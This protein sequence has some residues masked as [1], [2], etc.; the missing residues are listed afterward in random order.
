VR[1]ARR[2]PAAARLAAEHRQALLGGQVRAALD[3]LVSGGDTGR[4]AIDRERLAEAEV[5]CLAHREGR[6]AGS[7][8]R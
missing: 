8:S 7:R 5:A 6:P 1:P 2:G 4:D 3:A